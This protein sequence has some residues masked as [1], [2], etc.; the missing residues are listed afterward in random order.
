MFFFQRLKSTEVTLSQT[1]LTQSCTNSVMAQVISR[2]K[3][4]PDAAL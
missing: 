4:T 3:I 2:K 1:Y